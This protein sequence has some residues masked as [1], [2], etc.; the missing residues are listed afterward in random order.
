LDKVFFYEGHEG[1]LGGLVGQDT[2]H[3]R[4]GEAKTMVKPLTAKRSESRN[5]P[6]VATV[7]Q[8]ESLKLWH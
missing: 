3:D 8:G 5:G 6:A 1:L 7:S 2:Y 4:R